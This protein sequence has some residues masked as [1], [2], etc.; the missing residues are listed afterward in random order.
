MGT[1]NHLQSPR[2]E[3]ADCHIHFGW[4]NLSG[5]CNNCN[6]IAGLQVRR[7][8]HLSGFELSKVMNP[9]LIYCLSVKRKPRRNR[10]HKGTKSKESCFNNSSKRK[11]VSF[12]KKK[13]VEPYRHIHHI[14]FLY[15]VI[16]RVIS[17]SWVK[18]SCTFYTSY[19]NKVNF[20]RI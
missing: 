13:K 6:F 17:A 16:L 14:G 15:S 7:S 3:C 1:G 19:R 20:W 5:S 4:R 8:N 9:F 18:K 12:M 2:P 10:G 11:E